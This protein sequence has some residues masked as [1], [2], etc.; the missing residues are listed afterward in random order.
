MAGTKT[1]GEAISIIRKRPEYR[2]LDDSAFYLTAGNSALTLMWNAYRW[3]D[4]IKEFPPF[5]L[6]PGQAYHVAP[7]IE[8]PSDFSK[9]YEADVW[10]LYGQRCP[11]QIR[12]RLKPSLFEGTPNRIAWIKER[13]GFLITPTPSE[14]WAS[15]ES[16][17]VAAYKSLPPILTNNNIDSGALPFEDRHYPAFLDALDWAYAKYSGSPNAGGSIW[18][19]GRV[20]R[21]GKLGSF[22]DSLGETIRSDDNERGVDEIVPGGVLMEERWY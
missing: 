13:S 20:V 15:P 8:I 9:L 19:D 18:Q 17:V 1:V 10:T 12:K 14:A 2:S 21:T 6:I 7:H 22:Y 11:L 3:D 5:Y 16:Q 4:S